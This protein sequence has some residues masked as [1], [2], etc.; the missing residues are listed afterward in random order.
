[1]WEREPGWGWLRGQNNFAEHH[2]DLHPEDDSADVG[3]W[4]AGAVS[5]RTG[6]KPPRGLTGEG[7]SWVPPLPAFRPVRGLG[8]H[9]ETCA[10][11]VDCAPY[12]LGAGVQAE[13]TAVQ[14]PAWTPRLRPQPRTPRRTLLCASALEWG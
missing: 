8:R 4:R 10:L 2:S 12:D 3:R 9:G 1:M 13:G 14:P 6:L 11:R 5:Y 7:A